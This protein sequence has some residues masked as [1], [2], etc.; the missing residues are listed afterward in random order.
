VLEAL[1]AMDIVL[2]DDTTA[3]N[4]L[5]HLHQ[6]LLT[7]AAHRGEG[8]ADAG[9]DSGKG[10]TKVADPGIAALSLEARGAI[11]WAENTHRQAVQARLRMCLEEGRCT[12][13]EFQ[14][15][16]GDVAAIRLSLGTDGNP[17]ASEL[18]KWLDSRDPIPKGTFWDPDVKLQRLS[19]VAAD[20]PLDVTGRMSDDDAKKMADWAL[21]RKA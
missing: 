5:A 14:A 17:S 9:G 3:E 19:A 15:R 20:P 7:A 12:P 10:E 6:A 8:P 4:F 16:K 18:E 1:A 13:A 2:S 21:G 11:A